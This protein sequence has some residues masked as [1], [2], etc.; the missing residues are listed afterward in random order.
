[1]LVQNNLTSSYKR[2]QRDYDVYINTPVIAGK[3]GRMKPTSMTDEMG[4]KNNQ[5]ER[6]KGSLKRNFRLPIG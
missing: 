5:W 3:H 4:P 6:N 1:M 2:H